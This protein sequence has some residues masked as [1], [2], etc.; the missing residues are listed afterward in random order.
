MS[1]ICH[2]VMRDL[3]TWHS[4]NNAID[5]AQHDTRHDVQHVRHDAL[6]YTKWLSDTTQCHDMHK[7]SRNMR[8]IT[9]TC[10]MFSMLAYTLNID[11]YELGTGFCIGVQPKVR[12]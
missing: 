12:Y 4:Q 9:C 5:I 1:D 10:L 6:P 2:D 11:K 3:I 8:D 7:I